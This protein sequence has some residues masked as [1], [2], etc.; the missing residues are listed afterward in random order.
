MTVREN[1][2]LG[3]EVEDEFDV[4][5]GA[6]MKRG[7]LDMQSPDVA[8]A[9]WIAHLI[10]ISQRARKH[11]SLSRSIDPNEFV[12]EYSGQTVPLPADKRQ[13]PLHAHALLVVGQLAGPK[14]FY[15]E[16]KAIPRGV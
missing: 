13:V 8:P 15:L 3:G 5:R 16:K 7:C 1:K 2:E 10:F 14:L 9:R 11:G 12:H 6:S 4:N